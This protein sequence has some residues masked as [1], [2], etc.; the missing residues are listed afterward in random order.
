MI[1]PKFL[2][3]YIVSIKQLLRLI[4]YDITKWYYFNESNILLT[5][6]LKSQEC[7]FGPFVGEFGHLLSHII[8]LITYLHAK[9]IKITYMGPEIHRS[10]FVDDHG[11][12]LVYEYQSLRDF[13]S[14]VTPNCNDLVA[15]KD[16][17]D[18]ANEFIHRSRNSSTVFFDISKKK[19]YWF[20]ICLWMFE[21]NRYKLYTHKFNEVKKNQVALFARKKGQYSNVRGADWD[22]QEIVNTILEYT[23]LDVVILGH[24]GFSHSIAPNERVK[25]NISNNNYNI[26]RECSR[27]NFIVNQLS[28][29]HYLGLYCNTEVLLLLKGD[30]VNYTNYLKDLNIRLLLKPSSSMVLIRNMKDLIIKLKTK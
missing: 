27:S 28:G 21:T 26:L 25:I 4:K 23:S 24:P 8:P 7:Y 9:G 5:R 15:P 16:V 1:C 13:Y 2:N 20:G 6:A 17:L 18:V 10:L 29:T 14:E 12:S 11:N 19:Y 30:N 22:F 3:F